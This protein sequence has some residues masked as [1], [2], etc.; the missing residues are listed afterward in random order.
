M[1]VQTQEARIIIAIE[2]IRISRR[3]LSRRRTTEIYE[4][5]EIILYTRIA[6]RSSRSNIRLVVQNLTKLEKIIIVNYILDRDSRRFS[7]R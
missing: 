2:T 1:Q 5:P 3:K 6:G 4:I 7:L